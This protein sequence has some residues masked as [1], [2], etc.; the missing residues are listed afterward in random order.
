M[1]FQEEKD[2]SHERQVSQCTKDLSLI[3]VST[4]F[5]YNIG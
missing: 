2:W 3:N 4:R 1:E 5:L